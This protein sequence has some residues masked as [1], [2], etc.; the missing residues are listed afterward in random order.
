MFKSKQRLFTAVFALFM[1]LALTFAVSASWP[2]FQ[3]TNTNNG[4]IDPT[5]NGIPNTTTSPPNTPPTPGTQ[6]PTPSSTVTLPNVGAWTG[7]DAVSII[8]SNVIYTVYNSG[9]APDPLLPPVQSTP[10]V[11]QGGARIQATNLTNGAQ[12]WNMELFDGNATSPYDIHANNVSQL[13]TPIYVNGYLYAAKTATTVFNKAT[14]SLVSGSAS[15]NVTIAQ[16]V[17]T[18]L[19]QSDLAGTGTYTVT[20]T[21]TLTGKSYT[22]VPSG[23]AF[24]GSYGTYYTYNGGQIPAGTYTLTLAATGGTSI[25]Y[26]SLSRFDWALYSINIANGTPTRVAFGEGQANTPINTDSSYIYWGIWGGDRSYY[27][28]PV[29]ATTSTNLKKYTPSGNPYTPDGKDDFYGAGA[30]IVGGYVYFGSDSGTLYKVDVA[31]FTARSSLYL[32]A[33]GYLGTGSGEIRSTLVYYNNLLYFTMDG[34]GVTGY[35]VSI[36]INFGNPLSSRALPA[37]S[38]ST[39]VISDNGYVYVGWNGYSTTTFT[40]V[41]GVMGIQ[42][43]FTGRGGT[44]GLFP[45]YTGD[46]VQSSPI[47]YSART[48]LPASYTDYV[49]FTTNADHTYDVTPVTNHNGYC[50]Q[51]G[52]VGTGSPSPSLTWNPATGGTYAL[53]G[54]SSD[55]GY[56]VYG[57]DGNTLYIFN[58]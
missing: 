8:N 20:L 19:V 23:T 52:G 31:T 44:T 10:L 47:V 35:L 49:Y 45:V 27:Q 14:V 22:L 16:S 51:V 3:N 1:V 33:G 53:Q 39:P 2:S 50:Y 12:I 18:I 55:G 21:N 15:A 29:G 37:T 28:L 41:G 54:F 25:S 42:A 26:I 17:S 30:V 6:G 34:G 32:H 57:D 40:S 36:D 43:G 56:L 4:V 9:T 7:V 24:S 58:P 48:G 46:P 5:N 38:V 13:S 11:G